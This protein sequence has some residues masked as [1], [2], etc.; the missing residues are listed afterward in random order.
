VDLVYVL[1]S[2]THCPTGF[3]VSADGAGRVC[4]EIPSQFDHKSTAK[5]AD[6]SVSNSDDSSTVDSWYDVGPG[7]QTSQSPL[8]K[9]CDI[10]LVTYSACVSCCCAGETIG[11]TG[12]FSTGVRPMLITHRVLFHA[13]KHQATSVAM[14]T[15]ELV[16][17]SK[18][19]HRANAFTSRLSSLTASLAL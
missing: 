4:C 11:M 1:I 18:V 5:G 17:I 13:G 12:F 14:R 16:Q 15:S 6:P 9:C 3:L 7:E 8:H 19:N 10:Y 2:G